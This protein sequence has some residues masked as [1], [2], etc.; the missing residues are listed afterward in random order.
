MQRLSSPKIGKIGLK[1]RSR[2]KNMANI[3]VVDDQPF[4][5]ELLKKEL[6]DEGHHIT[7]VGDADCV[8]SLIEDSRPDMVLLDLYLQ[9]FEGWDLLDKIKK[10]APS[11][12]VLIVSAY[13]DFV[14]DPRL[15]HA[16]G[17]VIKDPDTDQLKQKIRE[18]LTRPGIDPNSQPALME[19]R[20]G[21]S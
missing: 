16:D 20:D 17:Y 8:M 5:G 10:Y 9:G 4:P 11:L 1:T 2:R 14:S 6:A 3:L 15:A 7:C 19:V 21:V 12:P 18:N 13:E